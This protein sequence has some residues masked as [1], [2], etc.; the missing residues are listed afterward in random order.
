MEAAAG[1]AE[2]AVERVHQD[3]RRLRHRGVAALLRPVA[4]FPDGPDEPGQDRA[5]AREGSALEPLDAL[6]AGCVKRVRVDAEGAD[7]A[8][9]Q[10][11]E[12]EHEDVVVEPG[13]RVEDVA[14]GAPFSGSRV[15]DVRRDSPGPVQ[16]RQVEVVERRHRAALA[17]HSEP[18]QLGAAH[19][20]LD[21]SGLL[22]DRGHEPAVLD[23]V[24]REP[25]PVLLVE[26][27]DLGDPVA[28][29][30]DALA[31]PQHLP[32]HV[33]QLE[34][35]ERPERGA[36]RVDAVEHHPPGDARDVGARRGAR[37]QDRG[38][39]APARDVESD[40]QPPAAPGDEVEIEPDH[41]PSENEIRVVLGEPREQ[42][43]EQGAF[44]RERLDRS[45]VAAN[46][47]LAHHEHPLVLGRMQR[48]RVERA[49]ESRGLDVQRNPPQRPPIVVAPDRGVAHLQESRS[50]SHLAARRESRRHESLHEVAIGGLEVGF[51]GRDA[52]GAKEVACRRQVALAPEVEGVDGYAFEGREVERAAPARYAGQDVARRHGGSFHEAH[53]LFP[54]EHDP[55]RPVLRCGPEREFQPVGGIA[56]VAGEEKCAQREHRPNQMIR[57]TA[58]SLVRRSAES[59]AELCEWRGRTV[60]RSV[61]EPGVRARG[62]TDS[63]A[64]ESDVGGLL[65]SG[66]RTPDPG[67]RTPDPGPRTW[68]HGHRNGLEA[69]R[70]DRRHRQPRHRRPGGRPAHRRG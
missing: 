70:S 42:P 33:L 41:V 43:G 26:A 55:H 61:R 65:Y 18:R 24:G 54:V 39:L 49:V 56:P 60:C 20:E 15:G 16:P 69:S 6:F 21:E 3:L 46:R 47:R 67:P 10:A 8:W 38:P 5:F 23:V 4:L 19:G 44:V 57:R 35:F 50:P 27:D 58:P 34:G 22:D 2:D 53:R 31:P 28:G 52:P 17:F 14:S 11:L 48:N 36:Q 59:T 45:V 64:G 40:P 7:D 37:L 9:I 63:L 30:V 51:A 1:R 29:V 13:L 25:G 66:R 62:A 32:G 68:N 12:V